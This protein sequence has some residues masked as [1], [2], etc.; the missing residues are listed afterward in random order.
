MVL[1][2]DFSSFFFFLSLQILE[3][4]FRYVM[5]INIYLLW[6][7]IDFNCIFS[8][9]QHF[10][11]WGACVIFLGGGSSIHMHDFNKKSQV[12]IHIWMFEHTKNQAPTPKVNWV[13]S[14]RGSLTQPFICASLKFLHLSAGLFHMKSSV[15]LSSVS[16][17]CLPWNKI[18]LYDQAHCLLMIFLPGFQKINYL[19]QVSQTSEK[20]ECNPSFWVVW[21]LLKCAVKLQ[22]KYLKC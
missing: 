7:R 9:F 13:G 8:S 16:V 2:L 18:S 12:N 14:W 3:F 1:D 4:H 22:W 19:M 20:I 15:L 17:Y 5:H 21:K 11:T 6:A 10:M